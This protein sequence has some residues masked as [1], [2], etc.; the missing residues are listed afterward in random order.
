MGGLGVQK[1]KNKESKSRSRGGGHEE[2]EI[3]LEE[4]LNWG[5]EFS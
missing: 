4:G 2:G 3:A 1:V 5:S